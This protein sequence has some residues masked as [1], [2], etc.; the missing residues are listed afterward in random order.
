MNDHEYELT[1][2]PTGYEA[3]GH[4]VPYQLATKTNYEDGADDERESSDD[5][6]EA[7][8]YRSG[9]EEAEQGLL[10]Q[11]GSAHERT[12]PPPRKKIWAQVKNIV[13]ETAPTLLLT[14]VGLLFTG[15]LLDHVS[16]WPAMVQVDQLIMIIP[17]I[18]NLKGNLEMN[19]SARLGT[20]ANV[21][22]LDDPDVRRS[23]IFGNLSLLQVQASVVSFV[24]ACCS[25]IL[26][27]IVPRTP[28]SS[29]TGSNNTTTS[30]TVTNTST[31]ST[32]L[33]VHRRPRPV[34]PP[35]D[36]TRKSGLPT[37]VMVA[38]TSMAAA[39]LSS[40]ILGGFMCFLIVVCRYFGLDPDNIAPPIASCLGDLVTLLL[41]GYISTALIPF[42]HTPIPLV[43]CVLV[44]LIG[45]AC[46]V[47]TRRN[48]HV[49]DLIYQG[50]LPLFGAMVISSATGI[51]LDLF[52]SRYEGFALL[53]VVISGLPGSV[54]AI[55]VSRMSTALHAAALAAPTPRSFAIYQPE[56]SARTVM[57]TLL[58]VTVPVEI[59]F[60]GMLRALGWLHLPMLFVVFSVVFFCCAVAASLL[61]G[62]WLTN[63]LWH[64]RYDPDM[65]AMPIHSAL[66]DLIGQILLVICF[67]IVKRL[68][69]KVQLKA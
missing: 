40:L 10:Q 43:V 65:Y 45:C 36:T 51:V 53:A 9:L 17:V 56:P 35:L 58:A 24:A 12:L 29:A 41:I 57:L 15:E 30:A 44:I 21:G 66:M 68:G 22:D 19:L 26:G 18:L 50:W 37:F 62:R 14:T 13:I 48:S 49:R 47:S 33:L 67:E 3:N 7:L 39:C 54:G 55:F 63:F 28:A 2:R 34:L 8:I 31:N 25:L 20:A 59:L 38:S 42:L 23:M 27:L 32:M 61:I 60:L 69:A 52:V 11:P 5:D 64:K 4:P 1:E 6:D 46:I 16:R